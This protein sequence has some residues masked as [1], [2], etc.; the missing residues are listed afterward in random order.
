M[1]NT[2][3]FSWHLLCICCF[4]DILREW[5][6]PP[7]TIHSICHANHGLMQVAKLQADAAAGQT[8]VEELKKALVKANQ[9]AEEELKRAGDELVEVKVKCQTVQNKYQALQ[10]E[11]K[12]QQAKWQESLLKYRAQREGFKQELEA[13]QQEVRPGGQRR[14]LGYLALSI[15]QN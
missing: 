4:L 2:R 7:L 11:T 13:A 1:C 6:A 12:D 3:F 9:R 15:P 14:L 8:E 10:Q 5:C